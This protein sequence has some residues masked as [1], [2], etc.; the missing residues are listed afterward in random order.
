MKI[1]KRYFI[2]PLI[3]IFGFAALLFCLAVYSRLWENGAIIRKRIEENPVVESVEIQEEGGD[4]FINLSLK[5]ILIDCRELELSGV[6]SDLSCISILSIGEYNC[7]AYFFNQEYSGSRLPIKILEKVLGIPLNKIND[8]IENYDTIY[9]Y[10]SAL[11]DRRSPEYG[12]ITYPAY[13]R[14]FDPGMKLNTIEWSGRTYV[15]FKSSIAEDI[16]RIEKIEKE[17]MQ[18]MKEN[19]L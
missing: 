19:N 12:D 3:A 15:L 14:F 9:R 8:V 18:W 4:F 17:W 10:I 1:K 11:P 2:I 7:R 5:I 13:N 6:S 16:R